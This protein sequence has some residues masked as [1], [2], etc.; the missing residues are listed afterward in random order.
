MFDL[1]LH[2]IGCATRNIEKELKT[3]QM[4]GYSQCSDFFVMK[5]KKLKACLY[6]H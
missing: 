5:F 1:K 6:Q 2:H 3:F 4:L